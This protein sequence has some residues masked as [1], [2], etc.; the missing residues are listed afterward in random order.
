[1]RILVVA[2]GFPPV[3]RDASALGCRDIVDGLRK[4]GHEVLVL[5]AGSGGG[6]F[7]DGGI[8]RLLA[9]NPAFIRGWQDIIRKETVNQ[10]ALRSCLADFSPRVALFFP[11]TRLSASLPLLAEDLGCPA[12]LYV[13]GDGLATWERDAWFHEQPQGKRGKRAIRY[14][15]RKFGLSAFTRPLNGI[16][17]IFTSRYF[18]EATERV[19]KPCR[20]AAVIPPGV[21][22]RRFV[23][24]ETA[25]NPPARLLFLGPLTPD[26]GAGVAVR[27]LGILKKDPAVAGLTLSVAGP[28]SAFPEE[29]VSLHGRAAE[30]GFAGDVSFVEYVPDAPSSDLI[31]KHDLYLHPAACANPLTPALLEA[32]ACGLPVVATA[33][34]GNAEVLIDGFNALVIPP[35]NPE[36]CA[37]A[38]RRLLDD[39][40]LRETLRTNA[41][42]T[43]EERFGLDR[44]IEAIDA[45]L[46]E[47]PGRTPAADGN[48]VPETPAGNESG[49]AA[50]GKSGGH[51]ERWFK[52]FGILIRLRSLFKPKKVAA[53]AK[54]V[55]RSAFRPLFIGL[56]PWIYRRGR[57]RTK[58]T[59][60]R[61]ILV[62][63]LADLG[64]VV[65]SG[66]FLRGLRAHEPEARIV[67]AVHPGV[68]NV[69]EKCP[70]VDE[71]V[72]FNYRSFPGWNDA[73]QG[74]FRWW[75]KG[76]GLAFKTFAGH[77]FDLAV[78]IRWNNDAPQ[79]A[80]L[81]LMAASGAPRRVAYLDPPSRAAG[82]AGGGVNSLITDGPARG[83]EKHEVEY[84]ADILRYLGG[85]LDDAS[86]EIW[87]TADDEKKAAD[88]LT[89]HR[90][91]PGELVIAF[92]PG[93]A[94]AFRRWPE[95]RFIELGRWLQEKQGARIL[96]L[97]GKAEEALSARIAA[98]LIAEKTAN[99]AGRTTI[100][101]MASVLKRCRLFV[102]ND[103]GPMH[104]AVAAGVAAV[105]L[106]GPGEYARFRPW[107]SGHDVVH[108][109]L[110]CNPC[111]QYCLF[112][113]AR[114]IR[115]ISVEQ[116]KDV[117]EKKLASP[118]AG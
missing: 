65:L 6:D 20:R 56:F 67:L 89:E 46:S 16:P 32:M 77:R 70:Y 29:L 102:G 4:K 33:K 24:K 19:G 72:P 106:F 85:W 17:A 84:Q 52:F 73:F 59:G 38:V 107:G 28:L 57:K 9:R 99:L 90:I 83:A 49:G 88:L 86:L 3:E 81:I 18:L 37:R 116:V 27:A 96:I 53:K 7:R 75:F 111:S 44:Q 105:G 103:S 1:M 12:C 42:K 36:A 2:E 97:S 23:F 94:W 14:L 93:A 30:A 115:G 63:Q 34:G 48:P 39:P 47:I 87:T 62:V 40:S 45:F 51:P 108:L 104:V 113:E 110:T 66:P 41:R 91:D 78:S 98:G 13:P 79:A 43:I 31:L 112:G 80:S 101:E 11:F 117:L 61:E 71:I 100:R 10:A 21:D 68:M 58:D 82:P 114:C 50:P 118:G 92:A 8:R 69:I 35:E 109:G 5:A 55:L 76:L 54:A 64:D 25:G 60:R 74:S 26:N 15:S 22:L 95:E